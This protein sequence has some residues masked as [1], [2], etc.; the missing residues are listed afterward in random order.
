[1]GQ[2]LLLSKIFYY[3]KMLTKMKKKKNPTMSF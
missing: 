1:M 3:V 2:K